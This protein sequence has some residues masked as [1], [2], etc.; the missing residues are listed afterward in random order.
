LAIPELR[1]RVVGRLELRL[2]AAG[3]AVDIPAA[4]AEHYL[5]V[6]WGDGFARFHAKHYGERV[7]PTL[8]TNISSLAADYLRSS[9]GAAFL[10]VSMGP[11][12]ARDGVYP[13]DG[14]AG[15]SRDIH[16][17]YRPGSPA[18]ATLGEWLSVLAD[19]KI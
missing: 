1:T 4:L 13:V 17:V 7:V 5:Y 9:G 14:A 19:L 12:L 6:D 11:T 16:L 2:F 18:E 3:R 10:P 15:F 8:R